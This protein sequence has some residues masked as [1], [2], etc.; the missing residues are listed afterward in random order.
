MNNFIVL[1]GLSG[2]GKTTI[3]KLLAE[4]LGAELY[5]TPPAIFCSVRDS[6]DKRADNLSRFLFYLSGIFYS[7]REIKKILEKKPVVCDRYVLT[8]L[9][10]H[11]AIGTEINIPESFFSQI[12]Q[13]SHVFLVVCEEEKRIRRLVARG[14]SHN[15]VKERESGI[16]ARFLGEYRKYAP[17][18][19]DNSYDDPGVAVREILAALKG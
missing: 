16:E 14:L 9:C 18:E 7:S 10:Y 1:E 15:D 8:T 13:P 12:F 11:R 4:K 6:I 5:K 19:I 2:S 17:V 3:A